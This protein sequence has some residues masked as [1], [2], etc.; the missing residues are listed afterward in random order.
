[1][2]WSGDMAKIRSS[3]SRRM[4]EVRTRMGE[5]GGGL[6]GR[7]GDEVGRGTEMRS[8]PGEF[9]LRL[10][11]IFEESCLSGGEGHIL[12][13]RMRRRGRRDER[14]MALYNEPL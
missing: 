13:A 14:G 4:V 9:W 10:E 1:V 2:F 6:G 5:L 12:V 8:G 11:R 3:E 7:D